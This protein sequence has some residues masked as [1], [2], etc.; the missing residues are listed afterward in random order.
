MKILMVALMVMLTFGLSTN[1]LEAYEWGTSE[2]SWPPGAVQCGWHGW[3]FRFWTGWI[4]FTFSDIDTELIDNFVTVEFHLSVTNHTNGEGGLDGLIDVIINPGL[5]PTTTYTDVL[6]DNVDPN[7]LVTPFYTSGTYRTFGSIQVPKSYI[8]GGQLIVRVDRHPD[9]NQAPRA[10]VGTEQPI[11]MS[12]TPPT[13]P[14]GVY[15][16]DDAHTVHIGVYCVDG[17]C[18]H[19]V[20]CEGGHTCVSVVSDRAP[21]D[22]KPGS[23][24]NPLN[25]NSH[26]VLP[27]AF[28]GTG[29][30][31][32]TMVDIPTVRLSRADGVGGEVA[33]N[34][35]P[36]GPHSVFE[37][38]AT[39]FEGEP[40]DCDVL[41]GDGIVDLS[42]KFR[43]DDVVEVLELNDLSMGDEVELIITGLLTDG[44][45]FTSRGDC[46][47]IVP[48]GISNLIV[49]SSV[50]ELFI[51][52][53]PANLC[54]VDDSGF[55]DFQRSYTSGTGVTLTAPATFNDLVFSGWEVDGTPVAS[56]SGSISV[57]L[58]ESYTTAEAVYVP[59][60]RVQEPTPTPTPVPRPAPR[61]VVR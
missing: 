31:D 19:I 54:N 43:T 13:V 2:L 16:N 18:G 22:I 59:V 50:P 23:C 49:T 27:V 55:A 32:V 61:P 5:T 4:E 25:R 36:P 34:E 46:I 38:V 39:P 41:G 58:I 53:D 60:S 24:P 7:N 1:T 11:D 30:F 57:T 51:E 40:C 37:D 29:H 9:A 35:G 26:G 20:S 21:L 52:V 17:A 56:V 44:T 42:M 12:T 3:W 8:I 28:V 15:E 48:L 33:P 14:P 6:L 47:L 45:E 10:P